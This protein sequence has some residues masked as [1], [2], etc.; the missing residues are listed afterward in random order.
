MRY[1]D[2]SMV[3]VWVLTVDDLDGDRF[4]YT[5]VTWGFIIL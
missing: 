4:T 3:K 2:T 1:F 5:K